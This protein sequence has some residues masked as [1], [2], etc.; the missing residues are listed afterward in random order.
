[1]LE[2]YQSVANFGILVIISAMYITQT[3]KMIEKITKVVESNTEAMKDA[4]SYHDR[5]ERCLSGMKNDIDELKR[6][7][8]NEEI[9]AIL[10]R[11]ED[12]VDQLGK[13]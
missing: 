11:L 1:M 13:E 4:Q 12:K 6:S 2:L 3:P 10:S 9:K 7:R 8:D 5:L